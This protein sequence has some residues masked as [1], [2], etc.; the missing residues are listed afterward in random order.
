M[1]HSSV[2]IVF[3]LPLFIPLLDQFCNFSLLSF[4]FLFGRPYF[5]DVGESIDMPTLL[6]IEISTPHDDL[7]SGL[8]LCAVLWLTRTS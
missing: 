7:C 8:T 1:S 4:V 2:V 5:F 3:S 6:E